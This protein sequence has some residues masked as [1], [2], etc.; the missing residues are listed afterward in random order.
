MG[1][2][3]PR[4]TTGYYT[5]SCCV[6]HFKSIGEFKLELQSR[7]T[8]SRSKLL[9]L[10]LSRVTLKFDGWPWKTIGHL[11]ILYYI[12]LLHH[13]KAMGEFKLEIQSGN[14]QFE[15][16][17][18]M[19]VPCDLEIWRMALKNIGH[20]S[21]AASSSVHHFI[22]IGDWSYSPE[23]PNLGPNRQFISRVTLTF[24]GWLMTHCVLRSNYNY[25]FSL[26]CAI[27]RSSHRR[28]YHIRLQ[29]VGRIPRDLNKYE[30]ISALLNAYG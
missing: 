9:I 21:Y 17:R 5:T 8:Q 4:Q 7:N 14:A 20:L 29:E 1:F 12:M 13:F 28:C 16:N 25:F 22:A 6:Y 24:G 3:W 11:L 23:T 30:I 10:F 27:V 2:W 19:F 18:K 26:L 15:S